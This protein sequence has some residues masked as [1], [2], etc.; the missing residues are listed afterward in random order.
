[1]ELIENKS[2]VFREL[3]VILEKDL[4]KHVMMSFLTTIVEFIFLLLLAQDSGPP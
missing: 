4:P 3:T 1:M 2:P